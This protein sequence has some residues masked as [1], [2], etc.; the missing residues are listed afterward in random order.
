MNANRACSI[1]GCS[2]SD[3]KGLGRDSEPSFH[4]GCTLSAWH[5][6]F[7][8]AVSWTSCHPSAATRYLY[9]VHRSRLSN[10]HAYV[11][12]ERAGLCGCGRKVQRP[13]PI[14]EGETPPSWLPFPSVLL[15][16]KGVR[17]REAHLLC[18]DSSPNNKRR[19]LYA[20]GVRLGCV[21]SPR[22]IC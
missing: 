7:A 17:G 2:N 8:S 14:S 22:Q 5:E 12:I 3:E 11:K 19:S 21:A 10:C 6:T 20:L 4:H 15:L 1:A 13:R 18:I 16:E 9:R